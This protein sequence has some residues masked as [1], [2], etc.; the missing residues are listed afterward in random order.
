MKRHRFNEK[1]Y[2]KYVTSTSGFDFNPFATVCG[3]R[4]KHVKHV[5]MH[6]APRRHFELNHGW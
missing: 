2:L 4:F 1:M 5:T 3:R 6:V